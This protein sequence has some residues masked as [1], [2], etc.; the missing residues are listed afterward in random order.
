MIKDML[1]LGLY[2]EI[3]ESDLFEDK[4]AVGYVSIYADFTLESLGKMDICKYAEEQRKRVA[5][6]CRVGIDKVKLI[7]KPE[8]EENVD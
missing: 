5:D 3:E 4:N 7:T 2:F 1:T 8:Y 6:H